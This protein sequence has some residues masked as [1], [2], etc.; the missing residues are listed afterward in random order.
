VQ[1]SRG[2]PQEKN[3]GMEKLHH[4][5][6]GYGIHRCDAMRT[7]GNGGKGA[8]KLVQRKPYETGGR[9]CG[10]HVARNIFVLV[11]G[12]VDTQYSTSGTTSR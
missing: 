11:A 4:G 1:D 3:R 8:W 9:G 5:C 2:T 12:A 6:C 7:I 10:N